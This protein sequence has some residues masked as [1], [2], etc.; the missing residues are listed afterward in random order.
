MGGPHPTHC[1]R[2]IMYRSHTYLWMYKRNIRGLLNMLRLRPVQRS[3]VISIGHTL[4]N[5]TFKIIMIF[6]FL[7]YVKQEGILLTTQS[8]YLKFISFTHEFTFILNTNVILGGLPDITRAAHESESLAQDRSLFPR[9]PKNHRGEPVF[10]LSVAKLRLRADV[11]EGKHNQ[12]TP[13][14]LQESRVEYHPFNAKK[15]KRDIYQEVRRQ[16]FIDYY[17]DQRRAQGLVN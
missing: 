14:Q 6:W 17:L 2:Y 5:A 11:E 8:L 15:L 1:G 10:D 9:Q 13:S 3:H 7:L 12:S 16:K 4:V